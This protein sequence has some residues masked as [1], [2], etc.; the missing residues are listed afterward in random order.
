ME[1]IRNVDRFPKKI[2]APTGITNIRFSG[3]QQFKDKIPRNSNLLFVVRS[4]VGT[5]HVHFFCKVNRNEALN[6]LQINKW[7]LLRTS[8][9]NKGINGNSESK[10]IHFC[11]TKTLNKSTK[12]SYLYKKSV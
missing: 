6:K 12:K 11:L 3:D 1:G 4:T 10:N 7:E 8:G 5:M 9:I 2:F